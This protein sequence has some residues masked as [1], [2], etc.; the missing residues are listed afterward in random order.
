MKNQEKEDK[1]NQDNKDERIEEMSAVEVK[2][3]KGK[4]FCISIIGEIEGH[5]VLP[6]QS[7]TTKYEHMLPELVRIEE[8]DDIGGLLLMLNTVGGDVEAGLAIAEMIAGMKK[9]TVSM[10]L[11]GGHSIGVPLAVAAKKSFI[12]PSAT[13]TVHPIRMTGTVIGAPQTFRQM[14]KVQDRLVEFV[15]RNSGIEEEKFTALMMETEKIAN[16]VGTVLYGEEAVTCG[17]IDGV[18]GIADAME[19]LH[20]LMSE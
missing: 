10:V 5:T 1:K 4:I 15:V 19:T 9:P 18:G 3:G 16:D 6:P 2:S 14:H 12:V 13:M 7:K 11:G 8:D 17:L 20:K